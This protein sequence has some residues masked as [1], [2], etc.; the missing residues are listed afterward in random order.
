MKRMIPIVDVS[1]GRIFDRPSDT[2]TLDLPPDFD[3]TAPVA[4]VDARSR[5]RY[6]SV[7]GKKIVR[8]AFARPLSWRVHGEDC[9]VCD[10]ASGA[11]DPDARSYTLAMV[12]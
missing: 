5:V 7:N 8:D 3:R 11:V 10:G 4:E 9:L 6:L 2:R 1:T 12:E